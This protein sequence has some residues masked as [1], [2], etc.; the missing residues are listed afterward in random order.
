MKNQI[1]AFFAGLDKA[2]DRLHGDIF[3]MKP[4]PS[5]NECSNIIRREADCQTTMLGEKEL[6]ISF[7]EFEKQQEEMNLESWK[8]EFVL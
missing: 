2:F 4:L 3:C 6:I 5:L 7:T 8:R 1:Y